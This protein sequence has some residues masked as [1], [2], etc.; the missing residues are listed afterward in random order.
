M[1]LSNL[2]ELAVEQLIK[3]HKRYDASVLVEKEYVSFGGGVRFFAAVV[4]DSLCF[5]SINVNPDFYASVGRKVQILFASLVDGF[6]PESFF[7]CR[8]EI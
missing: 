2:V 6:A 8:I 4:K 5:A 3:C 7:V 1:S